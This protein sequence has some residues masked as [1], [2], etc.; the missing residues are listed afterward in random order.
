MSIKIVHLRKLLMLFYAPPNFRTRKIRDDIRAQLRKEAGE[1]SDGGDFYT[2][3]WADAKQHM[4]GRGDLTTSTQLRIEG[5]KRRQRLYEE[6]R[7]GFLSW[8]NEKR[9][10]RNEPIQPNELP[11]QAR[12]LIPNVGGTVKVENVFALNSGPNFHRVIYPYFSEKPPIAE[13]AARLGLWVLSQTLGKHHDL[14]DMRI[15]DVQRGSSFG[16]VDTGLKGDEEATFEK[17]YSYLI[18]E[19]E[20]LRKEY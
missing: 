16:T 4:F 7:D 9:R 20:R 18:S 15:L 13:E 10:W 5:N 6:S 8:W 17:K 1:E 3:F 11:T 12:L 14:R 19:W 2:P